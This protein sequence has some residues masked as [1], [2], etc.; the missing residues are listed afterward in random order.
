MTRK[1][2]TQKAEELEID[3][4]Q[5]HSELA[6]GVIVFDEQNPGAPDA[7]ILVPADVWHRLVELA[8]LAKAGEI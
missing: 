4:E 1:E 2:W 3:P 5:S 6:A 8:K 7:D